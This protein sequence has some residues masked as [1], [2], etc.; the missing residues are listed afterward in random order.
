MLFVSSY[1]AVGDVETARPVA[2]YKYTLCPPCILLLSH[3]IYTFYFK[4]LFSSALLCFHLIPSPLL[5]PP[6]HLQATRSKQTQKTS[7]KQQRQKQQQEIKQA[8]R[9]IT[10][11]E[12]LN[13]IKLLVNTGISCIAYLRCVSRPCFGTAIDLHDATT[14]IQRHGWLITCFVF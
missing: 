10:Q 13:V 1:S 4:L 7:K 2:D 14:R 3:Y 12:S 8:T 11:Q 9:Q 5:F 6:L